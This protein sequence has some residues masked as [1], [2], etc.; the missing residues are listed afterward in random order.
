MKKLLERYMPK[1]LSWLSLSDG[2]ID[3]CALH[4][5]FIKYPELLSKV[6]ISWYNSK[7][8]SKDVM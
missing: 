8:K 2:V 5:T 6:I 3:F 4:Y 1:L 7:N